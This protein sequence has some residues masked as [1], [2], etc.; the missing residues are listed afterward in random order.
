MPLTQA[1]YMELIEMM[2][3]LK[4]NLDK[5]YEEI[6]KKLDD[7]NKKLESLNKG[8]ERTREEIKNEGKPAI[9]EVP[10]DETMEE[11]SLPSEDN[12]SLIHI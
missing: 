4:E 7:N 10:H 3:E 5:G 11:L 2:M 8:F 12:L 9:E 6:N 1:E